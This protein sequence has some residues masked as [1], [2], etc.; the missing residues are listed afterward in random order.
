MRNWQ[1]LYRAG[2]HCPG[3]GGSGPPPELGG[4]GSVQDIAW[5]SY[6]NGYSAYD[7]LLQWLLCLQW[8]NGYNGTM[9]Q[10]HNGTMATVR[11]GAMTQRQRRCTQGQRHNVPAFWLARPVSQ[12]K[13]N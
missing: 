8:H 10:W 6:Y 3:G 12:R 5:A 1:T 2:G 13:R 7:G 11:F 9:A 4:P